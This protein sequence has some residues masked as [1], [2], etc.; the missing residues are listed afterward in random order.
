MQAGRHR[1]RLESPD[2]VLAPDQPVQSEN[3]ADSR[4][5]RLAGWNSC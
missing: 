3:S 1:H 4:G 5:R 2:G